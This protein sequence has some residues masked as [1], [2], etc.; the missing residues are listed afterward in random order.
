MD[1]QNYSDNPRLVILTGPQGSGNHVW[2][3]IF[4]SH[5]DVNGWDFQGKYWQGHHREPFAD[6]WNKPALFKTYDYK[7]YNVT[8]ISNPYVANGRHRVPKYDQVFKALDARG[9][10]Y[11]VIQLGRN[12]LQ[13]QQKR[14]RK[15]ITLDLESFPEADFFVSYELLMLYGAKYI[16]TIAYNLDFPIDV[17]KA[18]KHLEEDTNAKY[19][20][21][22]EGI[23]ETDRLVNLSIAESKIDLKTLYA[24]APAA[25]SKPDVVKA[26]SPTKAALKKIH[27]LEAPKPTKARQEADKRREARLARIA[28][29]EAAADKKAKNAARAKKAAATRA[30]NKAAKEKAAKSARK[31]K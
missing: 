31:T 20:H 13:H 30:K 21:A 2:S 24:P 25:P 19:I 5:P 4:N 26:K 29:E 17:G 11:T 22:H 12:I 10:N 27:A 6:C 3:K 14:L 15:K 23:T 28:A 9:V 1:L 8:S 18:V 7:E 16:E